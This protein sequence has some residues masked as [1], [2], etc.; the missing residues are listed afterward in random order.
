MQTLTITQPDDWHLHLR[1]EAYLK[2]TVADAASQFGRAIVMPNLN[3]PVINVECAKS[4]WKRIQ[5]KIP[6]NTD[7][8]PLMTLYITDETTPKLIE[9]AKNAYFIYAAKLYPAGATTNSQHGVVSINKIFP[10]LAAMEKHDLPLLIHGEV[11]DPNVDIFDSE[12]YFIEHHLEGLVKQFPKLRIVLEHITTR[13]AVDFILSAPNNVAATI[14]A[15]HLLLSRN[16]LLVGGIRPHYYCLPVLKRDKDR[17]ALVRVATMGTT[18]FFLGTDSAPHALENKE[19][20]CGCAGI[21]TGHNAIALYAEIFDNAGALDKL[22]G[23]AS[24]YGANFYQLG[25]NK[26]QITLVKQE[27]EIPKQ[28]TYGKSYIVPFRAGESISW[29]IKQD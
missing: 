7:F 15:H 4:Y 20:S 24:F 8:E 14:T 3:S 23:F 21:Y 28:L 6:N 27:Q 25:R 10:V 5:A 19:A 17:D 26:K 16:D 11:N 18:K 12:Q 1:D 13:T 9:D 22:E 29:Q 2:R